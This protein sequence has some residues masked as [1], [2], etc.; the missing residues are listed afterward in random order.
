MAFDQLVPSYVP[1]FGKTTFV[2][3]S[4]TMTDIHAVPVIYDFLQ[5]W[6]LEYEAVTETEDIRVRKV[7]IKLLRSTLQYAPVLEPN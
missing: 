7:E 6:L 4:T 2:P 3:D 1:R 5:N